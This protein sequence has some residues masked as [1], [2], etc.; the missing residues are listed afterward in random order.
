VEWRSVPAR[1]TNRQLG[2]K[3][4]SSPSAFTARVVAV[5]SGIVRLLQRRDEVAEA[6]GPD[7]HV[8]VHEDEGFRPGRGLAQGGDEVAALLAAVGISTGHHDSHVGML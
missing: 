4:I 3:R 8:G 2:T 6:A 5:S 1:E 7:A